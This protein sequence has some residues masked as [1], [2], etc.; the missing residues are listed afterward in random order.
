MEVRDVPQYFKI[1]QKWWWVV[2]LFFGTTIGTML[3]IPLLSETKYEA[4][5]TVQV[6]APPPQEVPLYSQFGRQAL[7][8]EIQQTRNG[9]KEFLSEGDAPYLA[10]EALPDIPMN[11]SDL[12][13]NLIV[14]LPDNSQLMHISVNASDPESAALL[15]NAVVELGLKRYGEL[16]AR[17]TANTRQF[18]EQQLE[19]AREELRITEAE[20]MQFQ[21]DNKVGTLNRVIEK[22]DDLIRSLDVERDLARADGSEAKAQTLE[23]IIVEREAELQDTIGLSAKYNEL[24]A[25]VERA[26]N[27][28]NFLLDRRGEAQIKENQL[29]ELGSIQIITTARPP[30][31]PVAAIDNKIVILGV[32]VSLVVSV[33]LVF[34]LEYLEKSGTLP[35]IQKRSEQAEAIP[36]SDGVLRP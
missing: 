11:G 1:I 30:R 31:K 18:I 16:R 34:L 29:L 21:I 2:A 35:T 10:L 32:L 15:A 28:F 19:G 22:Q 7:D 4:I 9:L 3:A 26:R 8:D 23:A 27:T 6:T 13:E 25:S 33:L 14:E 24:T 17:A 12:R 20:L 5:V 36:L